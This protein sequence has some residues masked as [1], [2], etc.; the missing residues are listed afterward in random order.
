MKEVS[1]PLRDAASRYL[2]E[3]AEGSPLYPAGSLASGAAREKRAR[4]LDAWPGDRA[5]L[6]A[7][8]AEQNSPDILG[9]LHP[10]QAKNLAAAAQSGALFVLTG[11]QPGLLGGPALALHK[12]LT[13]VAHARAAAAAL[14]RP[15]IP[16]FWAAGDDSDLAESNAA[17]FLEPAAATSGVSLNF[18]DPEEAIPMSLR[19]PAEAERA[20]LLESLPAAWDEETRAL[21]RAA[22]GGPE[23]RDRSLTQSFLRL[24]QAL[25]GDTGL[26]F[27]DGFAAAARAQ[28]T[29]ARV[30]RDA[31]GFHEALARGTKRLA[32]ALNQPP[33]VPVR[34]GTVPVFLL[35]N[36]RRERL[37]VSD[38]GR[39]YTAGAE[40]RDLRPELASRALLHSALTRPLVVEALFPALGHVLGPAELR[41]FAQI[42]DVFPAF[43]LS[44]P[45]LA[46]RDQRMLVPAS[47]WNALEALGFRPEELFDLRP[48]L[49]RERLTERAWQG[50]PAAANFP[51]GAQRGLLEALKAY[52]ARWFPGADFDASHRRLGRAFGHYREQARKRVFEQKGAEALQALQPLLRWLG[53]GAQD[54]H[55]NSLSLRHAL[56]AGGFA[57]WKEARPDPQGSACATPWTDEKGLFA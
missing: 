13:T 5:A 11:Q 51:E 50:H 6:S 20:R 33:Q 52:Q 49:A 38:S 19:I 4:K 36:G 47:G 3:H 10:A 18:D 29:L 30:A 40:A 39:L 22:Y 12:A 26:L 23:A 25:L 45:L 24:M 15:V 9:P 31:S 55:L 2:R 56:G 37:F 14:G 44:F 57:A 16:V 53:N 17:E 1:V 35:E 7:W 28:G 48:S 42:A 32:D 34:P 27:V 46:P 54:R 43:G 41:Y 8:L 21:A